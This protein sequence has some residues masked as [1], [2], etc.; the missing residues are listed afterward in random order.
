MMKEFEEMERIIAEFWKQA[1]EFIK[2]EKEK[3]V[4]RDRKQK[5]VI[6]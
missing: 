2:K 6:R 4:A 1:D 5:Q 3:N